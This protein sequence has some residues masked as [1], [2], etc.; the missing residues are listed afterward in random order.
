MEAAEGREAKPL[1]RGEPLD[2]GDCAVGEDEI[3]FEDLQTFSVG[4]VEPI[5]ATRS[6]WS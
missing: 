3:S 2:W 1:I 6:V 5:P 4:D